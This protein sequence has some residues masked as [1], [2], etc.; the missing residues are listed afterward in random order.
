M[1]AR[2]WLKCSS[3]M[4]LNG[5]L[6]LV[7]FQ[8]AAS[9]LQKVRTTSFRFL[10]VAGSPTDRWHHLFDECVFLHFCYFRCYFRV[11]IIFGEKLRGTLKTIL[12]L[13]ECDL[14]ASID[15]FQ[16]RIALI[17]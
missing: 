15:I 11:P 8:G 7:K 13:L 5:A 16:K 2:N 9:F 6:L 1:P 12:N 3:K 14:A 17:E 4:D 10:T